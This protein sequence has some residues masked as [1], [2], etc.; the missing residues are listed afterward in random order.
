MKLK[1]SRTDL[2]ESLK[3]VSKRSTDGSLMISIQFETDVAQIL[4]KF[5]AH[6]KYEATNVSSVLKMPLSE[7]KF[8]AQREVANCV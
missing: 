5:F 4:E 3:V 8:N 1:L 2:G 7:L 6:C